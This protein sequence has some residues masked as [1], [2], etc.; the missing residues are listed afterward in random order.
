MIKPA[1]KGP[2]VASGYDVSDATGEPVTSFCGEGTTDYDDCANARYFAHA[3]NVL[4]GCVE[5]MEMA[6]LILMRVV[7]DQSDNA[8]ASRALTNVKSAITAAR[9]ER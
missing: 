3:A 7:A 2:F 8:Q 6:V 9:G 1:S 5:A 4:P